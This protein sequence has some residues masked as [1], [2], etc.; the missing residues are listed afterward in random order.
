MK[1]VGAPVGDTNWLISQT[2]RI[3]K[4]RSIL[5]ELEKSGLIKV[6]EIGYRIK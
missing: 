6:A 3:E 4:L 1:L 5:K 2:D